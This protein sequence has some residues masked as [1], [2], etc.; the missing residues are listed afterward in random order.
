[1]ATDY[2]VVIK[3]RDKGPNP[4]RW[5]IY[6]AGRN[7][8]IAHSLINFPSMALATRAGKESLKLLLNGLANA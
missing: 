7:S 2:S 3:L 5:E 4:W 6:R 8:L 1:V